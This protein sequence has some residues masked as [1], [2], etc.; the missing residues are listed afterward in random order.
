MSVR[1]LA[2]ASVQPA[3]FAFNKANA[4]AAK[5]WIK[6]YPKGREQSAIIPLLMI[7]QEQE[8]WVTKAAIETISDMLGMPRIRGLEVATF[9]TQYQL[10]PVGTRAH[11]QVCGTTPCMLRGSEALMDVCRSKIHHDQF[12]TNDKGTLSWEEVECLG[13]CVNAPMVMVFKDTFEDLTPERL[14]EIIDLYDAGKG[15]SVAP[16]PQNGRTGSEPASGLTTLKSEKAILKSTRDRE[17]REAAK[18]AKAAPGAII[19]TAVPAPAAVAPTPPVAPSNASKPKTDAPETSPALKTPSKTKVAP[20]AEKAASVSA[21]LHSAANANTAAPEVEKVSKQ[22]NG[23][24]AKAEPASAFKAPEAKVPAAK[25]AKPS[26]EDKNRPAGIDRP[27]AVD[28]LKLI[29]GVGPKIEGI[30]HTLGIFTFAQVASW[31]K[32]EREWVDG[33]LSFQGRIDRDNWVA[34]AKALAKGGVAEYIRVF[35][36]KP[37]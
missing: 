5:Q 8:G 34:Q 22:R 25:P 26:L 14:A 7:A 24:T 4:A 29:S 19:A 36:K 20:A 10:N 30:L 35:G 31:K 6:K 28:D 21:P 9:Y 13:A 3:S 12:H 15:A 11:I 27:A 16:G 32:A 17:A 23:P 37:V 33:Y 1:R 18:A 2:E